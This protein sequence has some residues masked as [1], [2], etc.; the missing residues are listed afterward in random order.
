MEVRFVGDF[1]G[2][3][4]KHA[5]RSIGKD[6]LTRMAFDEIRF[7]DRAGVGYSEVGGRYK[8]A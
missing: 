5:T 8:I 6:P 7:W 4:D 1:G 3:Q 2:G